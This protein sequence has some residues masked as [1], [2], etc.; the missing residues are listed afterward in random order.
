MNLIPPADLTVPALRRDVFAGVAVEVP[1]ELA[2]V[3]PDPRVE[4]AHAELAEAIA[5]IDHE[6]AQ[7]LRDEIAGLEHGH[8]LLAQGWTHAPAG[9]TA[10]EPAAAPAAEPKTKTRR[11]AGAQPEE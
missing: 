8:G 7:R 9:T 6:A 2:G 11:G 5:A 10:A 4:A 1:D 3:A